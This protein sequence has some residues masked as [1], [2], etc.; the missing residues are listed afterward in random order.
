ME[1]SI[2]WDDI[3]NDDGRRQM[4]NIL[5]GTFRGFSIALVAMGLGLE[6]KHYISFCFGIFI[7]LFITDVEGDK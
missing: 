6:G 3:A 7:Y 2:Y 1:V 4:N 5:I